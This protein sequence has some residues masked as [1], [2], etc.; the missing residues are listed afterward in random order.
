MKKQQK[1]STPKP[2][3]DKEA[4]KV[5]ISLILKKI[6]QRNKEIQNQNEALVPKLF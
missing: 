5:N 1:V 6:Q 4:N 3:R 2:P